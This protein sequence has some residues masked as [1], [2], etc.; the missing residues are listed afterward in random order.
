MDSLKNPSH[1][2]EVRL[3]QSSA[4]QSS[5][6]R[7]RV[8]GRI[9]IGLHWLLAMAIFYQLVLGFWMIELPKSPVGDR[10]SVV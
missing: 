6:E 7:I 5:S 9:A 10:K 3:E 2:A 4:L 1:A 8:Y